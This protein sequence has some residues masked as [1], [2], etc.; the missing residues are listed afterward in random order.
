[1]PPDLPHLSRKWS[2]PHPCDQRQ[3]GADREIADENGKLASARMRIGV[4]PLR[5]PKTGEII[6]ENDM[7]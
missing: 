3:T 2:R 1:L 5:R 4:M 6:S 7:L